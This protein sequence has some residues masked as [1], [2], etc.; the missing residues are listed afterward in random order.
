MFLV[1]GNQ[2]IVF[3]IHDFRYTATPVCPGWRFYL[4]MFGAELDQKSL[5]HMTL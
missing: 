2:A 4:S 3:L 1:D 5:V